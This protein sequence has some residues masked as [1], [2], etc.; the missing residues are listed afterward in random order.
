MR[1]RSRVNRCILFIILSLFVL[2]LA[3]KIIKASYLK[4]E[5]KKNQALID[6]AVSKIEYTQ[7]KLAYDLELFLPL[8]KLK[9][10]TD[11]QNG[12]IYLLITNFYYLNNDIKSYFETV[13]RALFYCQRAKNFGGTLYLYASMAKYFLQIGADQLAFEVTA[14]MASFG[15]I[16]ECDNVLSRIQAFQVYSSYLINEKEFDRAYL[17][18]VKV[19]EDADLAS[20]MTSPAIKNEYERAGQTI[21]ATILLNQDKINEA[22]TMACSLFERYVNPDEVVSQ[23]SAFDFYMPLLEIQIRWA[24][25]QQ[26]FEKA[27]EYFKEYGKYCDMFFF[28]NKK[29]RMAGFLM[30]SLPLEMS[31]ERREIYTWLSEDSQSLVKS[32]VKDYTFLV[33]DKFSTIMTELDLQNTIYEKTRDKVRSTVF[34]LLL[35]AVIIL[36]C[37]TLFN[38]AQTDGLTKLS[39]RGALNTKI[40]WL[41]FFKIHYSAIMIDLD[42]FKKINDT[43]GHK[44]GDEVLKGVSGI[45]LD[46][47]H[48]HMR[49][50]RYGG[51]EIVVIFERTSF[52]DV[53]RQAESIRSKI[54]RL[55]FENEVKITASFGIGTKPENPI[56]QADENLYY[57][58]RKGKNIVAYKLNNKQ[59]LAERRLEIRNPMPDTII[60]Q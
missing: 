51:E 27:I 19:V 1:Y 23:F 30:S 39:N 58:K 24:V 2:N 3:G 56:I 50:Y 8:T 28:K 37:Y 33:Y 25:A 20:I 5:Q 34:N 38:E 47:E 26:N 43:Y 31:N 42:D 49:A 44:T 57:A 13:G 9:N 54:C 46:A 15:S 35:A 18:A 16:Y 10:L 6:E 21:K 40:F 11:E 48:P 59:Y 45:V 22:Y 55:K 41:E 36:L 4:A 29:I 14:K 60:I 32:L 52:D 53:I 7:D 12:Q 17:A